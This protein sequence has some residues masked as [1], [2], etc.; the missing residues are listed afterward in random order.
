VIILFAL[1]IFVAYIWDKNSQNV[2][3]AVS[4]WISAGATAFVGYVAYWQDRQYREY[5]NKQNVLNILMNEKKDM[6]ALACE[7]KQTASFTDI[8]TKV[9][10]EISHLEPDKEL[11]GLDNIVSAI[12]NHYSYGFLNTLEIFVDKL[13]SDMYFI[14]GKKELIESI[15]EMKKY[16]DEKLSKMLEIKLETDDVTDIIKNGF[17]L[18]LSVFKH[19]NKFTLGI[20]KL[21][22]ILKD[23]PYA[24]IE[25]Y[26]IGSMAENEKLRIGKII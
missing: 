17:D 14:A 21:I 7:Y 5:A 15:K 1:N 26:L 25:N 10:K 11:A 4:G 22:N 18:Q 19:F 6:V 2:F 13:K 20:G 16:T 23:K 9:F 24:E 3:T 12:S 8:V